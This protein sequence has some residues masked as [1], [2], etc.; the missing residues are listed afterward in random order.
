[1]DCL[2]IAGGNYYSLQK[3]DSLLLSVREQCGHTTGSMDG[4]LLA[5]VI[6]ADI[7][8]GYLRGNVFDLLLYAF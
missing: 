1:M 4:L 2:L 6:N 3:F 7:S 5:K 8:A